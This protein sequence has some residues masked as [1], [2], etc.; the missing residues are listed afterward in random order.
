MVQIK[1]ASRAD[2]MVRLIAAAARDHGPAVFVLGT[3][4][5]DMVLADVI[6]RNR[7]PVD[8][9]AVGADADD[10]RTYLSRLYDL[11]AG[12]IRTADTLDEA[13]FGK[14]ALISPGRGPGA[15]P[16]AYDAGC[17]MLRFNPLAGWSDADLRAYAATEHIDSYEAAGE[18]YA[19]RRDA[20]RVA[21]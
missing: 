10:L 19:G 3:S 11:G 16:Y 4:L 15:A 13:L 9:V 17:R 7:I 12:R 18:T 6:V 14:Q 8:L 1:E 21:A 5:G 20:E 2:L